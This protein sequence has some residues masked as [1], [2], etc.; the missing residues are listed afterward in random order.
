MSFNSNFTRFRPAPFPFTA[1]P[2]IA[3]FWTDF[4]PRKGGNIYYRQTAQPDILEQISFT[5]SHVSGFQF[6]PTLAFIATWDGVPAFDARFQGLTNTFQVILAT[7]GSRSFAGFIYRDIQWAGNAQIGFNAGDG[8][9]YSIPLTTADVLDGRHG[10]NVMVPGTYVYRTDG[11]SRVCGG[12]RN[13]NY[14]GRWKKGLGMGE[15]V[16]LLH[17]CGNLARKMEICLQQCTT[18]SVWDV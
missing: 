15:D 8:H 12:W 5:T 10:S 2:L 6:Q 14:D 7:D 11:K 18:T 9:G 17:K 16:P 1:P 3:P 13:C 4:D